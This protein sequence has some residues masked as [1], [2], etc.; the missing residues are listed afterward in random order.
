[1][2]N[3]PQMKL[4]GFLVVMSIVGLFAITSWFSE[5]DRR[6]TEVEQPHQVVA[7]ESEC[8]PT[9]ELSMPIERT[10]L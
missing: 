10:K 3:E 1:M 4:P 2:N 5:R 6:A 9:I 7:L 8:G